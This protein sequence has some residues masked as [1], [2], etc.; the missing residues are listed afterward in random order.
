MHIDQRHSQTQPELHGPQP[1]RENL[2][3]ESLAIATAASPVK[4]LRETVVALQEICSN[5]DYSYPLREI[6][7]ITHVAE[8]LVSASL[9]RTPLN[10]A[11]FWG[12]HPQN[13]QAKKADQ[14]TIDMLGKLFTGMGVQTELK[15]ILADSHGEFNGIHNPGYLKN[16]EERFHSQLGQKVRTQY[17]SKLYEKH[18]LSLDLYPNE[19]LALVQSSPALYESL[20]RGARN[21]NIDSEKAMRYAQMRLQES[22]LIRDVVG[23]AGIFLV[24]G[25]PASA[26]LF[27]AEPGIVFLRAMQKTGTRLSDRAPWIAKA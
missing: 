4:A 14:R 17:L 23:D 9:S 11:I 5:T 16:I 20:M 27:P 18:G 12:P 13:P 15:V 3:S 2:E 25:D 22:G 26:P 19:A 7:G 8:R 6:S 21:R 1:G 24:I 10:L